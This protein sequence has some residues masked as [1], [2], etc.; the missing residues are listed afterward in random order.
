M[1]KL[2]LLL[3]IPILSLILVNCKSTSTDSTTRYRVSLTAVPSEG[4]SVSPANG[5]HDEGA[6]LDISATPNEG[7]LFIRWEGDYSGTS[8]TAT[9]TVD[10]DKNIE[11]IFEKRTY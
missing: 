11:A 8:S 1:K 9:I 2:F 3:S 7:W 6:S 4:G 10:G 5:Q